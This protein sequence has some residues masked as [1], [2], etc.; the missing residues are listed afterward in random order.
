MFKHWFWWKYQY[1]KYLLNFI[2]IYSFIPVSGFVGMGTSALF[3]P[4]AYNAV[5]TALH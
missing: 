1:N 2:D 3:C 4:E 5:K